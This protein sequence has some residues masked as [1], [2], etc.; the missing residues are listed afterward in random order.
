MEQFAEFSD[1]LGKVLKAVVIQ[2][3]L[4]AGDEVRFVLADGGYYRLT[5]GDDFGADVAVEIDGFTGELADLTGM[6][7]ITA[8]TF[9]AR[10]NY[11]QDI[12]VLTAYTVG[13]VLGLVT[14][15]WRGT[16]DGNYSKVP[17]FRLVT[18]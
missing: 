8:K 4:D 14:F 1:L 2:S 17:S 10:G 5:G 3:S 7:I 16:S 6:K 18:N 11:D 9:G 15:N 12:T 13:T